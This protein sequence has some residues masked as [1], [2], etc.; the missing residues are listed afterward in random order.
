MKR[1]ELTFTLAL[2]PLDYLALL[3]AGIAA[4]FS[5]FHPAFTAIRPIIFD[6]TLQGYLKV[7]TPMVIV[8]VLVFAASGLYSV[9]RRSIASELS[10]IVLACSASMA[11]VFA[12]TFFSRVLFESRWIAIAGWGLA[13]MFVTVER[14]MVRALQRSLLRLEIGT[15]R[16]IIIGK[17]SAAEAL[18]HEFKQKRRNA[19]FPG[20][21][22]FNKRK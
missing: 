16:I 11:L 2:V 18:V 21:S 20:P 14:L 9:T 1:S 6:L 15:H 19:R 17:T 8:F 5:R 10:R 22:K 12:I 3:A 13:I 7:V 4:Y